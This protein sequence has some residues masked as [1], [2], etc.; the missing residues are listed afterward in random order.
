[1]AAQVVRLGELR[2]SAFHTLS[3]S[4][5]A[6]TAISRQ[7]LVASMAQRRGSATSEEVDFDKLDATFFTQRSSHMSLDSGDGLLTSAHDAQLPPEDLVAPQSEVKRAHNGGQPVQPFQ[8]APDSPQSGIQLAAELSAALTGATQAG[9][10]YPGVLQGGN[11]LDSRVDPGRQVGRKKAVRKRRSRGARR[12]ATD[13]MVSSSPF[14]DAHKIAT[15]RRSRRS[16]SRRR[17]SQ[18]ASTLSNTAPG[19]LPSELLSRSSVGRLSNLSLGSDFNVQHASSRRQSGHSLMGMAGIWDVEP[20]RGGAGLS[21]HSTPRSPMIH[22]ATAE[23]LQDMM[24]TDDAGNTTIANFPFGSHSASQGSLHAESKGSD[25]VLD[26]HFASVLGSLSDAG[27][28]FSGLDGGSRTSFASAIGAGDLPLDN[29]LAWDS[30]PGASSAFNGAGAGRGV[31][32]APHDGGGSGAPGRKGKSKHRRGRDRP[33]SPTTNGVL[34]F[35]NSFAVPD[36]KLQRNMGNATSVSDLTARID[37]MLGIT[38]PAEPARRTPS[39]VPPLKRTRTL[40]PAVDAR[41]GASTGHAPAPH[42]GMT[43]SVAVDASVAPGAQLATRGL[44]CPPAP[45]DAGEQQEKLK[46]VFNVRVRG[47][48]CSLAVLI[49][50]VCVRCLRRPETW[51][52]SEAVLHPDDATARREWAGYR[53][54]IARAQ[55]RRWPTSRMSCM[56]S[57][58]TPWFSE[59]QE[60]RVVFQLVGVQ[61]ATI[62]A[63]CVPH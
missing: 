7:S 37:S 42:R 12:P 6:S 15:A 51:R 16:R 58:N 60:R 26:D 62:G 48:S 14:P 63:R 5:R 18:R 39:G 27:F 54:A 10:T 57:R 4:V 20:A 1:M 21:H 45:P 36:T 13:A 3:C 52:A 11:G 47:V 33:D 34:A 19:F 49:V 46:Q 61:R 56:R 30:A 41:L 55:P 38:V 29:A 35:A 8:A 59:P 43:V 28:D 40:P 25:F 9:E 23:L 44:A 22:R 50:C 2:A 17:A 32:A 24:D 31:A 53:P